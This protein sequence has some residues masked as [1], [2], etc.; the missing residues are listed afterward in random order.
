MH[1]ISADDVVHALCSADLHHF[2]ARFGDELVVKINFFDLS[3]LFFVEFKALAVEK[4]NAVVVVWIV[5]RAYHDTGVAAHILRKKGNRRSRHRSDLA[6]VVAHGGKAR[7][8]RCF[9]H[10]TASAS[11]FAD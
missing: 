9:Y 8:D 2:C 4:F 7:N 5:A 10:I 11:I 1:D 3:F 6:D